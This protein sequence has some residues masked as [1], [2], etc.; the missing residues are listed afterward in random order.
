M[1]SVS[2]S[3]MLAGKSS[4]APRRQTLSSVTATWFYRGE[5]GTSDRDKLSQE[6]QLQLINTLLM[7]Q[8]QPSV[9]L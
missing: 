5:T 6:E 8:S 7:S 2:E 1:P 4:R 3:Q 9:M